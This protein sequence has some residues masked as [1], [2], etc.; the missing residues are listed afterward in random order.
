MRNYILAAAVVLCLGAAAFARQQQQTQTNV[1]APKFTR[2]A[3]SIVLPPH[4]GFRP[5]ARARWTPHGQR[6]APMT[7]S[8]VVGASH[9]HIPLT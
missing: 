2:A 5:G 3:R 6:E 8:S 1:T 7:A 9:F 4:T